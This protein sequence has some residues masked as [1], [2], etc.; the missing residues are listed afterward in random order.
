MFLTNF[1]DII[2]QVLIH[3]GGDKVTKDKDDPG[4]TTKYGI[5][6]KAYPN[7]DIEG[8]NEQDAIQIYMEDYWAPSRADQLPDDLKHIYF[9]MCVNMG[10]KRAVRILQK[11]LNNKGAKLVVDGGIGKMTLGAAHSIN[12][13]PDRLRAYRI[14]YYAELSKRKPSLE[15]YYYGWFRRSLEV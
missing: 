15:K 9:D 10:K 14:K 12:L 11:A 7:V 2:K 4:G 13:E 6:K 3:E 1:I 5:S 8:L